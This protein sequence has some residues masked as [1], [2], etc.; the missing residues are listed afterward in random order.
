MVDW[1]FKEWSVAVTALLNGDT[2]LLIRKGGIREHQGQ[3]SLTAQQMLLLPTLEH[4]TAELLKPQFT[5]QLPCYPASPARATVSFEGWATVTHAFLLGPGADLSPLLP[6]L[7]WNQRFLQERLDWQPDR[8]TYAMVLRAYRL[9]HPLVLP[10]QKSYGGC[11]SWVNLGQSVAV[12][13]TQPALSDRG[14][15]QRVDAV[16]AALPESATAL[17]LKI[18]TVDSQASYGTEVF[19]G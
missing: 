17:P 1:A 5:A 10:W 19:T 13:T 2:V 8:P 6:Y 16:L 4:Q 11:R 3:F 15:G 12:E 14:Y 9:P 7:I 18:L